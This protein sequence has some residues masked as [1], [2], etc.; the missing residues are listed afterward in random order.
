MAVLDNDTSLHV[1]DLDTS[2]T[3]GAV[4]ANPDGSISY[5]PRGRFDELGPTELAT[6]TFTY[7]AW[8]SPTRSRSSSP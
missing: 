3:L 5:D 2:R 6:D 1:T 8:A 4:T 7:T